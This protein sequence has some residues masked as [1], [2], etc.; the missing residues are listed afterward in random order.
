MIK[1]TIRLTEVLRDKLNKKEKV[2]KTLNPGTKKIVTFRARL[3]LGDKSYPGYIENL[4][5]D[6]MYLLASPFIPLTQ[7]APGSAFMLEFSS[8]SGEMLNLNCRLKWSY[9]TPPHGL[10]KSLGIK[11]ADPSPQYIN[12]FKSL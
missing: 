8:P 12:F 6:D 1:D 11:V 4:T 2:I 5:E 10:T 7:S 3:I 9:R